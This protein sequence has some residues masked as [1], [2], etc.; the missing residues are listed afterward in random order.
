VG[1]W[2]SFFFIYTYKA[3]RTTAMQSIPINTQPAEQ[4]FHDES[5]RLDV[6]KV[7]DTIQGEG[8]YAGTPAV[9]VRLAGCNLE[10]PKCDTDYTSQRIRL[11]PQDLLNLVYAETPRYP[12]LD[13][14]VVI[15]N[16]SDTYRTELIVLTGG[17]PFRQNLIPFIDLASRKGFAVQ[18]ETNGTLRVDCPPDNIFPAKIVCSPKTPLVH[19][20][21]VARVDAWKYVV[22]FDQIDWSDGLPTTALGMD[23]MARLYRPERPYKAPIYIQPLDDQDPDINRLSLKAAIQSC[24]MFGHRLCIQLHKIAG[25]E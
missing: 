25:L 9:F 23:H 5:G 16:G 13:G 6:F 12:T 21:I 15:R 1:T 4:R 11:L 18:I 3:E 7:F 10:C 2:S 20:S 14:G 24:R 22:R 17:E 8:P 19:P